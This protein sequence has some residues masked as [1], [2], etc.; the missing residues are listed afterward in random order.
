MPAGVGR[1]H[2]GTLGDGDGEKEGLVAVVCVEFQD[3]ID[4]VLRLCIWQRGKGQSTKGPN[5]FSYS[6]SSSYT[7]LAFHRDP[8]RASML[9][10][11]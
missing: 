5:R 10:T 8:T 4:K 7:N 9:T 6:T 2:G 1:V 3:A 11:E